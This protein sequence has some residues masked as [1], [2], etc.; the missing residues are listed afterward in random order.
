MENNEHK[1]PERGWTAFISATV[2]V[3]AI[4]AVIVFSHWYH[5][6]GPGY[7]AELNTVRTKLEAVPGI[8]VLEVTWHD[9]TDFPLLPHLECI[10][11]RVNVVGH[12]EVTLQQLSQ[13]SFI[14]T[15]HLTLGSI[16]GDT[17]RHRG[18][19]FAG[20]Y[21]IETGEPVRSQFAGGS[22]DVGPAGKFAQLFPFTIP[23]VQTV[24]ER[25]D[26]I[27]AIIQTWP[28]TPAAPSTF[29]TTGGREIFYWV[30]PD[31][32]DETDTTWKS[33]T[34]WHM[35]YPKLLA[36]AGKEPAGRETTKN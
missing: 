11:A 8:E 13:A 30:V 31:G 16:Q 7:Y 10:T 9:D 24:V 6:H 25:Y 29:T 20:V 22:I 23:N 12:G 28:K 27:A 34:N 5:Y 4:T 14:E 3:A 33:D 2:I 32:T 36:R 18:E 21:K 26:E 17:F 1:L 15:P 19:G 35:P